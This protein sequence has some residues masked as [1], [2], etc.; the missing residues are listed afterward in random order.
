MTERYNSGVR[1]S[2]LRAPSFRFALAG[3]LVVSACVAVLR[4]HAS[5]TDAAVAAWGVTFDLTITLPLLYWFFVVRTGKARPL[6]IAPVFI[7]G[8]ILAELLL[9]RIEQHFVRQLRLFLV[10]AAELVLLGAYAQRAMRLK[11]DGANVAQALTG[12]GRFGEMVASEALMFYYAF[13]GWRKKA[14]RGFTFHQRSGWSSIVGCIIVLIVAE[15]IGMH[16]FLRMWKPL[17]AWA[18]TALDLW[19]IVWLLGDY[20]AMRLRP[21]TLDATTLHLRLGLR[22]N[23]TVSFSN[24]ESITEVRDTREWK[25]R[26]VLRVAIL[27]EPRWL[28]ALRDPIEVHGLVGMRKTVRAIAMLPDDEELIASLRS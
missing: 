10:P 19:A 9:P 5:A 3:L 4:T 2:V 20:Q 6:T 28:I 7:A 25:R 21:T 15:S 11:R 13:F 17:A 18:W 24:I 8:T 26:D 12:G 16:F 23:A 14:D 22:W 1:T 27:D